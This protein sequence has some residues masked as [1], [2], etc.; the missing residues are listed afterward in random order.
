MFEAG[1][2]NLNILDWAHLNN[3]NETQSE[4]TY[5]KSEPM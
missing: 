3:W 5:I 2:A 4:G 1:E